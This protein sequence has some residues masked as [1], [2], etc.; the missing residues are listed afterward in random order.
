MINHQTPVV[1]F[2]RYV[3][4]QSSMKIKENLIRGL[5][6]LKYLIEFSCFMRG[7]IT[8]KKLTWVSKA[9]L[10]KHLYYTWPSS[11]VSVMDISSSG[12]LS[13]TLNYSPTICGS[14]RHSSGAVLVVTWKV[15]TA[16]ATASELPKS[17]RYQLAICCG[18]QMGNQPCESMSCSVLF[19]LAMFADHKETV[20]VSVLTFYFSVLT[21]Y[22]HLFS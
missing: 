20:N 17:L 10:Q 9:A 1:R 5:A 15:T 7:R 8:K 12:C 6:I 2:W 11:L 18:D 22:F 4:L 14:H 16:N 13:F 19:D 3:I 21:F